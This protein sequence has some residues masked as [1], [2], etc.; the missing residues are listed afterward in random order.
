MAKSHT[1]EALQAYRWTTIEAKNLL[2][3]ISIAA[4]H[5]EGVAADLRPAIGVAI[6]GVARLLGGVS[7]EFADIRVE[8]P[9]G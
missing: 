8:V 7:R 2:L 5:A 9:N 4:D 3:C 6:D 1:A